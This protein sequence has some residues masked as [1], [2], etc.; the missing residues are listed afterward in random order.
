MI[1]SLTYLILLFLIPDG[2]KYSELA[3]IYLIRFDSFK[4][5]LRQ[6]LSNRSMIIKFFDISG[7]STVL[8]KID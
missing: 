4:F 7:I 8:Y 6:M 2:S 1:E 5:V 3:L